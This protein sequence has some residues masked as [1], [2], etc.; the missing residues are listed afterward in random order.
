MAGIE[1]GS[2][3]DGK[4]KDRKYGKDTDVNGVS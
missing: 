1:T 2:G 4:V 3:S